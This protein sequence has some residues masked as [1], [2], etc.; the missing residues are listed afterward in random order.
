MK[1]LFTRVLNSRGWTIDSACEYWN[2]TRETYFRRCN[3]EKMKAQLL[4]MCR[5]LENKLI[6]GE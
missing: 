4:C 3:N 1:H 6:E 5:G 2:I